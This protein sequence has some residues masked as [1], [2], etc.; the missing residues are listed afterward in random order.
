M[1]CGT[2]GAPASSPIESLAD[3]LEWPEGA[4]E[5]SFQMVERDDAVGQST[6]AVLMECARIS[7]ERSR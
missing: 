1:P 3:L 4:F 6:T 7:D 2:S 5:F